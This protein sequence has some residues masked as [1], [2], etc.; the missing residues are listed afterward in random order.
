LLGVASSI[1]ERVHLELE[2][3]MLHARCRRMAQN[4][5]KF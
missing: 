5:R 3:V 4:P 1:C 2:T